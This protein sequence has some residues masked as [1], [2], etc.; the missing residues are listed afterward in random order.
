MSES[1][2]FDIQ[3]KCGSGLTVVAIHYG[4]VITI[5]V[6]PCAE[7]LTEARDSE[8]VSQEKSE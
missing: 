7:C 5:E 8:R 1:I 2:D 4:R 3:C 6:D